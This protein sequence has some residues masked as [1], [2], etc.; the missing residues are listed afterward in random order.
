MLSQEFQR[1]VPAQWQDGGL[2]TALPRK[3]G[4]ASTL[5]RKAEKWKNAVM[6]GAVAL[7]CVA[8]GATSQQVLF[9]PPAAAGFSRTVIGTAASEPVFMPTTAQFDISPEYWPQLVQRIK[10]WRPLPPDDE[11]PDI[12]PAI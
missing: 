7:S 6:I 2:V 9:T 4:K 8:G 3:P 5:L 12:E 1:Y 11:G 10:L